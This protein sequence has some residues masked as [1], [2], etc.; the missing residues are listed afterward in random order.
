MR[1]WTIQ[2]DEVYRSLIEG[3]I[4]YSEPSKSSWIQ[5][6]YEE[7]QE[8]K[9]IWTFQDS[10]DWIVEQM[11][12]RN[13]HKP[14]KA[15]YPWWGWYRYNG[16][17][18]KPD[19]RTIGLGEKGAYAWC[20]ELDLP[21]NEVLISKHDDWHNV[22]NNCAIW[23]TRLPDNVSD[24][25]FSKAY[26]KHEEYIKTLTSDERERYKR[27]T[28]NT[29]FDIADKDDYLQCTFWELRLKDVVEAKRFLC[30]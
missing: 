16:K 9:D 10:Y 13:I 4:I 1:I 7:K 30:R 23:Y 29:I 22:L 11:Q 6:S 28:W 21:D 26:D 14:E 19:L 12:N 18:K 24:E 3:K 5:L 8:Y 20:I 2:S 27:E 17:H 25:D 15:S